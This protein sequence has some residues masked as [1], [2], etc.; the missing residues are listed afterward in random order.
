VRLLVLQTDTLTLKKQEVVMLSLPHG[1]GQS[2]IQMTGDGA[3]LIFAC[4]ASSGELYYQ[5][6]TPL[7]DGQLQAGDVSRSRYKISPVEFDSNNICA[8]GDVLLL[9]AP[10][11]GE[12]S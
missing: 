10:F 1:G 5:N 3:N 7:A 4:V 2:M 8:Y 6:V 12:L 11:A 9:F